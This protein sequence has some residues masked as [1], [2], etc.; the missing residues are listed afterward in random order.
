MKTLVLL[1][2][3]ML[4]FLFQSPAYA[5]VE[6]LNSY[7]AASSV[8]FLDFDGHTVDG[9]SWNW[10]GNP[11]TC[12]G[13]G[14]NTAQIAEIFN[15]VAE[16]YRPFNI[17]ITTEQEKFIAAP[18]EKRM[19]VV[20][21]T[22]SAWYGNSAGGVAF[23]RS[24]TSGDD[25]PCFV[26]SA[27]FGYNLKKISEAISHE[28]GHT[29][30]LYHQ[31][32]YDA[33]C[34][35]IAEYYAGKGTGE[36]GWA[37]IMGVGYSR[38]FTLWSYG[39]NS[40]GCTNFQSDLDIIT[41]ADNG[42]GYRPDDHGS[43]FNNATLALFSNNQFDVSGVVQQNTDMDMFHF[44]MPY[45]GRFQL[46][47]V[48][49]NVGTGN[50]GSDL[51]MQVTLYNE[52]QTLL[53]VYNPGALLNSIADTTLNSGT[54]YLRIE[55]KGNLYAPSYAS[56]GSYTL[57]GNIEGGI[58]LPLHKLELKVAQNEGKHQFNWIVEA[59]EKIER[60]VLEASTDGRNFYFVA[61][62]SPDIFSYSYHPGVASD[63]QYRLNVAFDD[64]HRYYSNVVNIRKNET[65][66]R[67]KLLTNFI[68]S[69]IISVNSPGNYYY[70]IV[71]FN[72]KIISK[73]QL[74]IG[75]NNINANNI[76]NGMYLI[77]FWNNNHQWI[78]KLLRQ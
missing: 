54:Y 27:L 72:G 13:S 53:N 11:I 35:R 25:T 58:S 37:P 20:I 57:K 33:N 42:F 15:R 39:P 18:I 73:G 52:S 41:S 49:Y 78:D 51:D 30:G 26:F 62:I 66:P 24:F 9:T 12:A 65:G 75:V 29:L 6:T 69:T 70:S 55:G 8:I 31:S 46:N 16:D 48:P 2:C 38:N 50:A 32:Q 60:Q 23:I 19:R 45:N 56:L 61:D 5:Q 68:N 21:T 59:D 44:T 77:R 64:G 4:T 40:L 28:A 63:I 3:M 67:P 76:V 7:P 43:T 10:D 71:D 36:I 22:T 17:N 1:F 34:Y 47:A 74:M 14:L